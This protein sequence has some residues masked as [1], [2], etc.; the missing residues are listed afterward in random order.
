M[1]KIRHKIPVKELGPTLIGLVNG[2]CPTDIC[3]AGC[4]QED[5]WT[6]KEGACS[7][8]DENMLCKLESGKHGKAMKPYFCVVWPRNQQDIDTF[9]AKGGNCQLRYV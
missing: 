2:Q 5:A 4:C 6:G 9:N 3:G 8:L 1:G 7:Q